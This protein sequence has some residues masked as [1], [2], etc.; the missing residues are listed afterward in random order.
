MKIEAIMTTD[1][2]SVGVDHTLRAIRGIFATHSLRHLSHLW[3][4]R[5]ETLVDLLADRDVLREVSPFA[6]TPSE[7]ARDAATL[8]KRAHQTMARTP[9]P[10][11]KEATVNGVITSKNERIM[12]RKEH[13]PWRKPTHVTFSSQHRKHVMI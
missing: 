6:D 1:S 4:L 13:Q 7:T 3:S 10:I 11:S 12:K 9:I 8:H 5:D 2:V